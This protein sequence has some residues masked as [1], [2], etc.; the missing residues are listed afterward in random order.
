MI[1]S[2]QPTLEISNLTVGY[3]GHSD[4]VR[5]ASLAIQPG[6]L[7]GLVGES[8]SGKTTLALAVMGFLPK[9]GQVRA[10]QIRLSGRPL[11]GLSPAEL[12]QMWGRELS[13]VPQDALGALNP[14]LRIGRQLTEARGN[15][16]SAQAHR[17][18]LRLLQTVGIADGERVFQQYPHQ[19]SG[20]MLQRI[21]IAM[22]LSQEPSLLILD[23][24]TSGL[25]STTE[26]V[27]QDLI[28]E[29][30]HTRRTAALYIS[31]SMG[32]LA[33]FADRVA[34]LYAG[35]LVEQG[36]K[37]ELFERP[38]HPYT[39]GLLDS[40]PRLGE[41]KV[42]ITLRA[43]RGRIPT[44]D[45]LPPACVFEPRCPIAQEICRRQRPPL[46][47]VPGGRQVRCHRWAEIQAGTVD[48]RQDAP[49]VPAVH[50]DSSAPA[51]QVERLSVRYPVGGRPARLGHRRELRALDTVSLAIGRGE[52]YGLVGESGSG[53]TSLARAVIGLVEPHDGTIQLQ[54]A[55]LARRLARRSR[56]T[57][58]RLQMVFQHPDQALNPYLTIGESLA[59]PLIRLARRSRPDADQEAARLLEAVGLPPEYGQRYPEQLSGGEQQRVAIAR[60][61]AALPE[62]VLCDEPVSSLDVSVQATILNLLTQL[63]VEH[64]TSML[65][66]S[67]DLAVVGYLADEIGVLY[68][69]RMMQSSPASQ[70][71]EPPYH[72][73]TEALLSAIPLL[74]PHASQQQVRLEGELPSL[75]APPSGCPFHTRCP[76]YLGLICAEQEP[77]WQEDQHG[78][79]IFCHIPLAE[80]QHTQARVFRMRDREP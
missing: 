31:H 59:R 23:E 72:P 7:C 69:G 14:T 65:F 27:I 21:V 75:T 28:Q 6:E 71:F 34:V 26:V 35:E 22:A 17:D 37:F 43:I 48:P 52:T 51:L 66:I 64:R 30:M 1:S 5:Q 2:T 49:V 57:L 56:S 40:V 36:P 46:E 68:L 13:I 62:L 42:N 55:E 41:S 63:Q 4:A 77:P 76:R 74:D 45:R 67:H 20:G 58:R 38:L 54:G 73:Y 11:I 32:A 24:P 18:G 10:G 16:P 3:G 79:R 15:R 80:L 25:D 60:A 53:K 61:F 8:G 33:K 12:R 19:L 9:G 70:L 39:Q 47:Q 44:P 29:L 50:P 78:N